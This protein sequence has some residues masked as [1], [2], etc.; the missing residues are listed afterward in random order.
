M[1]TTGEAPTKCTFRRISPIAIPSHTPG[2]PKQ[3]PKKALL[4]VVRSLFGPYFGRVVYK[5]VLG[6]MSGAGYVEL[7]AAMPAK[8]Q[9]HQQ[10]AAK[11]QTTWLFSSQDTSIITNSVHPRECPH[12]G[13]PLPKQKK[14]VHLLK[15]SGDLSPPT[16]G[17]MAKEGK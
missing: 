11:A 7:H 14:E 10:V 16:V 17:E 2:I 4:R 9:I 1:Q 5:Y 13:H 12:F 6:S 8:I 3:G 15:P